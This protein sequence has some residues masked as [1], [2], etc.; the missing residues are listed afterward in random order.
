[1]PQRWLKVCVIAGCQELTRV[2]R[3]QKHLVQAWRRRAALQAGRPT[4]AQRGYSYTWQQTRQRILEA[5][6]YRCSV[7]GCA[8]PATDVD[9]RIPRNRGGSDDDQNLVPLCHAHHSQKTGREGRIR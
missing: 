2:G 1:M 4:A 3:C 8:V 7:A 9:H 6:G 5:A